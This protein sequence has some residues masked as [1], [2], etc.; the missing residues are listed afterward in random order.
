MPDKIDT[1]VSPA[2]D[3]ETYRAIEGYEENAQFVGGV[4]N[5]M[6]DAY[7]T[8]GKVHDA[9]RLADSNGAFTEEQRILHV[10]QVAEE[11][12]L[13]ILK[14]LDLAERD[15]AATIAH[16]EEQL[17]RPL[18]EQAG[19]GSLNG[20]VRAFA[21]GL[22]RSEREAFMNATLEGDDEPTLTAILGA[23]SFLSGLTPL[24]HDHYLRLYHQKRRPDLVRRL[25][26]MQRF[27]DRLDR[28]AP[29]VHEQ[30]A[31]PVG[32][33]PGI[34][35]ALSKANE[36]ALAALKIEPTV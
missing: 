29:I 27:R 24:D 32:A 30:F 2:L 15:L 10:G 22:D 19:L 11:H 1:R 14:R 33:K 26:V 3:P 16:T 13:R 6:N 25:D 7:V 31:K 35:A 9:R 20:E 17:M 5:A 28:I 34:V 23:Q 4:V 12:K 18:T 36:Q 21:R 8:L